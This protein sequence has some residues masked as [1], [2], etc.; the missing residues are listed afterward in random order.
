MAERKFGDTGGSQSPSTSEMQRADRARDNTLHA[1]NTAAGRAFNA[2]GNSSDAADV[3]EFGSTAVDNS[4][5]VDEYSLTTTEKRNFGVR[6]EEQVIYVAR[7]SVMPRRFAKIERRYGGARILTDTQTKRDPCE[8]MDVMMVAVPKDSY[9]ARERERERRAHD[10]MAQF[11]PKRGGVHERHQ[12]L[13]ES[14]EE[15]FRMRR[16]MNEDMFEQMGIGASGVTSGMSLEEGLQYLKRQGQDP[17]MLADRARTGGSH[18]SDNRSAWTAA[19]RGESSK[20]K[21]FA[22]GADFAPTVNPRSA[23]GQVQQRNR[24]AAASA[25]N[26]KGG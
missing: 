9:E 25:T 14:S 8:H 10:Y 19:M 16:A 24:Q 3:R 4:A 12:E 2:V 23:L 18:R 20:G 5:V 6:D 26:Q 11:Q 21:T 17:E 7:D 1:P 13:F 15:N 22:T